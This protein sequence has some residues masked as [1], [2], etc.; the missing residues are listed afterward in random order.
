MCFVWVRRYFYSWHISQ[1][2]F[3]P[4][5]NNVNLIYLEMHSHV[6]LMTLVQAQ[7]TCHTYLIKSM[8]RFSSCRSGNDALMNY[9]IP[10]APIRTSI[11]CP[12]RH[13]H[14]I[15]CHVCHHDNITMAMTF[16]LRSFWWKLTWRRV[17]AEISVR[18]KGIRDGE[19]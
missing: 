12:N 5:W 16:L 14:E 9:K 18:Q 7:K 2:G 19:K 1:R 3:E 17:K 13:S 4:Q 10:E 11:V 6:V 8:K 15:C